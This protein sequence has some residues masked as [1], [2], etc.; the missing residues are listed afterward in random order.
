ME[1]QQHYTVKTFAEP[2]YQGSGWI[3]FVGIMSIIGG[4]VQ[5]ISIIGILWAW[6]PIWMGILLVQAAGALEQAYQRDD[7]EQMLTAM[8]KLKTYFLVTG[9]MLLVSIVAVVLFVIFGGMAALMS[10]MH[11][12]R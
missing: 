7:S 2:L 9:I 3:K 11:M 5:A 4:A 12:G 8:G 6:L 10:G 1:E